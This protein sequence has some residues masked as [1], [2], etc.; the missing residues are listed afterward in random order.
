MTFNVAYQL[1]EE[2]R[3]GMIKPGMVAN[4]SIYDVDFLNAPIEEIPAA[5][6]VATYVDGNVVYRGK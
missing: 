5:K 2:N 3:L 4:L 6:V 1:K